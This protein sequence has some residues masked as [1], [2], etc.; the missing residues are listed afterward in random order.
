MIHV[1]TGPTLSPDDPALDAPRLRVRPPIRHGDLFDPA[2]EAGDTVLILDGLYHHAPAIRHKEIIAAMGRGVRVIGA[3]SIGA[4]R[5]AELVGVGMLGVGSVWCAYM[6]GLLDGD[7]E[8]AVAQSTE[9]DL[10]ACTWPLVRARQA[11][12]DAERIGVLTVQQGDRLIRALAEVY[13]PH[14]SLEAVLRV[15]R[16]EKL[17]VFAEW[18]A[19]QVADD[20]HF[21]DVK[22]DD[23]LQAVRV[24][25]ELAEQPYRPVE[26]LTWST[27][28]YRQWA[29]A[30]AAQDTEFG[31]LPTLRRV[32]YQQIFDKEFPQL[33]WDYLSGLGPV[34]LPRSLACGVINPRADLT[35]E[36][37]A[38]RL[39]AHETEADRADVARYG[40]VNEAA[41][42]A[43]RGFFPEAI[44]E[45]VVRQMLAQVWRVSPDDL[46]EAAEYR[47]LH[48]AR[49]AVEAARPFVLGFLKDQ[50]AERR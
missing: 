5:A 46:D 47:G 49:E 16:R 50:K 14:R 3:G 43:Y 12:A 35:D 32:T 37:T 17:S 8:V 1:F 18:L 34:T 30:F 29:N 39:L 7:D 20:T 48:G 33:W 24:A 9:G 19:A 15:S 22:R 6:A 10:G 42:K 28:C 45:D 36:A 38:A 25:R 44:K 11:V 41:C 2:I 27:R 21:G 31:R 40:N 4:L 23:A 26:G 13:Y